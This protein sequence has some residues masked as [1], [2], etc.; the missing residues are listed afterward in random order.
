MMIHNQIKINV[1]ING[2]AKRCCKL[3]ILL[4]DLYVQFAAGARFLFL[5]AVSHNL[6]ILHCYHVL[7]FDL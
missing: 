5:T 1:N 6:K 4:N 7:N 3:N 2:E